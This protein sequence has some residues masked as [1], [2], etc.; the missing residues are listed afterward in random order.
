ME[1]AIYESVKSIEPA[2]KA[3]YV[4]KRDFETGIVQAC[5]YYI[6]HYTDT[7]GSETEFYLISN[8]AIYGPY[9]YDGIS[10][11]TFNDDLI[12]E[13]EDVVK[14]YSVTIEVQVE[15]NLSELKRREDC[16][17]FEEYID[18]ND[19]LS[20]FDYYNIDDSCDVTNTDYS[21]DESYY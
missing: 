4:D 10:K 2:T 1:L 16:D 3:I 13:K 20:I 6:N 5:E 19:V 14:S 8:A 15:V 21:I 9:K 17:S 18:N 11:V 12:C 7:P